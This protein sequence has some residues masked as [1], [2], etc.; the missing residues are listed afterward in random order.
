[1][2]E[3]SGEVEGVRVSGKEGEWKRSE[4]KNIL[5]GIQACSLKSDD[6]LRI[7]E[8]KICKRYLNSS[9]TQFISGPE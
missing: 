5:S 2:K 4:C 6:D 8:R 7:S 1:M 9:R 3:E